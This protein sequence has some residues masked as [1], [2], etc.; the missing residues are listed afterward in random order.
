MERTTPDA[1]ALVDQLRL[2]AQARSQPWHPEPLPGPPHRVPMTAHPGLKHLH[3]HWAL[4][5]GFDAAGSHGG[6]RWKQLVWRVAGRVTGGVLHEYMT[7]EREL[8]ANMVQYC[9]AMAK[10][11]DALERDIDTLAQAGSRQAADLAT[12]LVPPPPAPTP[13]MHDDAGTTPGAG[14]T[15]DRSA[16]AGTA[17]EAASGTV[18]G[19]P[20]GTAAGTAGEVAEDGSAANRP[21]NSSGKPGNSSGKQRATGAR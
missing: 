7:A 3:E 15:R 12:H 4:P 13:G 18:T 11:V 21:G 20:S 9:D 19:T 6:P 1:R 16:A 8:I 2:R 10:R 5:D 14:S 17:A